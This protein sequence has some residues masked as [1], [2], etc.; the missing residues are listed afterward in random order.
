MFKNYEKTLK[1]FVERIEDFD[2]IFDK[3]VLGLDRL[4]DAA[5]MMDEKRIKRECDGLKVFYSNSVSEVKGQVGRIGSAI[6]RFYKD[7]EA[8]MAENA[9]LLAEVENL[10]EYDELRKKM[11]KIREIVG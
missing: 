4:W 10:K 9:R 3:F 2:D 8:V 7:Y 5:D 11:D 6:E 1:G